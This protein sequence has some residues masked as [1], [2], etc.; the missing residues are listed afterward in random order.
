MQSGWIESIQDEMTINTIQW[1]PIE[2][3]YCVEVAK[4]PFHHRNP[5]DRV[6]IEL[7]MVEDMQL[8]V[9]DSRSSAYTVAR[10]W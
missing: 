4:L 8:L 1:L 5:F 2:I 6:L 10:I 9:R 3:P 7:A